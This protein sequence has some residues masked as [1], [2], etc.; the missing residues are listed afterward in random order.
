MFK[1]KT[2]AAAIAP[3]AKIAKNLRAVIGAQDAAVE[4]ATTELVNAEADFAR[5]KN[6]KLTRR[7]AARAEK[8]RAEK[9]L[10][11]LETLLADD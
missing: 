9:L 4:A 2:T 3:F 1:T 7:D 5:A 10:A 6:E 11:K 8:A